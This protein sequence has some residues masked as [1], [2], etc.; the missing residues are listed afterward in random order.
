M[1]KRTYQPSIFWGGVNNEYRDNHL[2]DG[3]HNCFLGGGNEDTPAGFQ[4]AGINCT[5]A[6]NLLDR[7]GF[8]SA[9]AGAFY[10]CGQQATAFINRGNTITNNTFKNVRNTVGTGVQTASVQAIYLDDQMSYV[11]AKREISLIPRGR[12]THR[13]L[14]RTRPSP[15]PFPHAC[16]RGWTITGNRFV[17]CQIGSFIGG[18]RDNIVRGNRYE[19]CDTA[20]HI[21]NRG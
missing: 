3:P 5:F 4:G 9:D 14:F 11:R 17:N 16:G 21:D 19:H 7:C 13:D 20:Q 6:G 18:G 8:E 12:E 2:S 10:T 15:R 1:W